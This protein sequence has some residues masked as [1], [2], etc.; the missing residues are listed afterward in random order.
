[1]SLLKY[2]AKEESNTNFV[3]P[4]NIDPR[5]DD[6]VPNITF[7]TSGNIDGFIGE[8]VCMLSFNFHFFFE[9]SC[10][11]QLDGV[12]KLRK[13]IWNSVH[14]DIE[15]LEWHL[16]NIDED[17]A[18]HMYEESAFRLQHKST[19]QP[20][21]KNDLNKNQFYWYDTK[22][23][24]LYKVTYEYKPKEEANQYEN[25]IR[26]TMEY[27]TDCMNIKIPTTRVKVVDDVFDGDD[28]KCLVYTATLYEIPC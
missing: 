4:G 15:K 24:L 19:K 3:F 26:K 10:D 14:V 23:L 28:F 21:Y 12:V 13:L 16:Y 25:T 5:F 27:I 6:I 8:N 20:W 7:V 11:S 9:I 1:M 22:M 2:F 18:L 17:S